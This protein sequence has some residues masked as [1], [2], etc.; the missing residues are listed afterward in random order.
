MRAATV[1]VGEVALQKLWPAVCRDHGLARQWHFSNLRAHA[2]RH[3]A[4]LQLLTA[5]ARPSAA[6]THDG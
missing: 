6:L 2:Q 3:L 4:D 5:L 1:A